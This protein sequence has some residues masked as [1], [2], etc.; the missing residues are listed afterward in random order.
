MGVTPLRLLL[1]DQA[2]LNRLRGKWTEIRIPELDAPVALLPMRHPLQLAA[3][4]AARRNAWQDLLVLMERLSAENTELN[5][6]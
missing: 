6:S 2:M 4:P 1:G 3:S 5:K